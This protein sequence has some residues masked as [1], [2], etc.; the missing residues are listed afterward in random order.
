[1]QESDVRRFTSVVTTSS[2]TASSVT[3]ANARTTST[4][5]SLSFC[6]KSTELMSIGG[7]L[8]VLMNCVAYLATRRVLVLGPARQVVLYFQFVRQSERRVH[9]VGRLKQDRLPT[10]DRLSSLQLQCF[11]CLMVL[12]P[13]FFLTV[14]CRSPLTTNINPFLTPDCS[15]TV[16]GAHQAVHPVPPPDRHLRR[17]DVR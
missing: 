13:T 10:W 1:M 8:I 12:V 11:Q 17:S 14:L 3:A 2:A 5:S 4:T 6:S 9:H 16:P 15:R 7:R